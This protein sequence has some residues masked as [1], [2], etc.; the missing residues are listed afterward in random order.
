M[1]NQVGAIADCIVSDITNGIA[2]KGSELVSLQAIAKHVLGYDPF[3]GGSWSLALGESRV[4]N[5][6]GRLVIATHRGLSKARQRWRSAERFAEYLLGLDPGYSADARDTLRAPVAAALLMPRAL[7]TVARSRRE[8][9]QLA[10]RFDVPRAAALM[11]SAEIHDTPTALVTRDYTKVRG[12]S[13]LLPANDHAAI[14]AF[15]ESPVDH[16]GIV[17]V[18]CDDELRQVTVM[19]AKG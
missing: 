6:N 4:G 9:D 10:F 1:T 7:V 16:R 11:R 14:R 19:Q 12:V 3:R 17:K 5:A 18:K 13:P 2:R 8:A 15:A